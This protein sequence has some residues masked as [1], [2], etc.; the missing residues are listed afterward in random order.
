M[1]RHLNY[2]HLLYFHSVAVEG[3][4]AAAATALNITPQTISGQIKLLEESLGHELFVKVGR[5]L[6]LSE[7]GQVVKE[8]SDE[9]FSLGVALKQRL[10][11][12]RVSPAQS[13][14]VGVLDSIPKLIAA[15]LLSE[16]IQSGES[17]ALRLECREGNLEDLLGEMAIH[18]LDLILSD[19][20]IPSG[21][22]VKAFNHALGASDI[23]FYAPPQM[24]KKLAAGFP[25]CLA[26]V[27]LLLPDA[28]SAIRRSLDH[29][30]DDIGLE[31]RI[32][33]EIDDSA[34]MKTLGDVGLGVYPAP[35]VIAADIAATHRARFIGKADGVRESYVVIS[36]QRRVRHPLVKRIT[37]V[38]QAMF[39]Q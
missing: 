3:S 13:L 28:S 11:H 12:E 38:G 37:D 32:V 5:R 20:V 29:W 23:G 15:R 6:V 10:R 39:S 2:N 24:A 33:A 9:I 19:R 34:L 17:Q 26:Q 14:R 30:F 27:P 22:H 21:Y 31:P 35:E 18:K 16:S 1:N 7:T 36:P 8:Y 4:V 25:Q